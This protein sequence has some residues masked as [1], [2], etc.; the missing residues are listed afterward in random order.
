MKT[1]NHFQRPVTATGMDRTTRLLAVVLS[2]LLVLITSGLAQGSEWQPLTGAENLRKFMSDIQVEWAEPDGSGS[3]GVYQADGTGTLYA[4]G[5]PFPRTWTIKGDDQFCIT[6]KPVS[7]CYTL[8][9]N[10]SDPTL[11][12]VTEV[13]SGRVAKI[14]VSKDGAIATVAGSPK[15][16]GNKGGAGAT[17]AAEMANKLANPTAALGSM[18]NNLTYT[19]FDGDLPD[20]DNQ[21]GWTYLFQP[22]LPF[23]LES[24]ANILFR[25]GIPVIFDTPV[26]AIGGGFESKGV[27]LGDIPFDLAYGKTFKNGLMLL[28]GA[29]GTLPTA[30]D[31]A[32]GKDQWLLGPELLIGYIQKWGAIGALVN[33]QWDV[34][35]DDDFDTSI[36]GGQYFYAF[37]LGNAWQINAGPS[38]SYN[39]KAASGN[40]LTLPLGIGLAKTTFLGGRP[41][42]FQVQY[43]NYVE[44][45]DSFGP[46]HVI[47]FTVTPV[48]NL[49]W[50]RK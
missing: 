42:K 39:H 41:W 11:Y 18:A 23:P 2:G 19:S 47:R 26:P 13:V 5:E 46:K 4:W 10:S 7:G 28:G 35:G 29:A 38:W 8:E 40:K 24:G 27:E 36:T 17:S 9:R 37:N 44:S 21:D 45:P 30:T 49:P 20:A 50:G 33:H 43:W 34:A 1:Q 16:V 15:E 31:D 48:I 12:R 6:G 3:R 25:P 32:L 14:R 22:S